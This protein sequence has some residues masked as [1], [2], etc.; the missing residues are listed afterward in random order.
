MHILRQCTEY[1]TDFRHNFK[2]SE[3]K[4]VETYTEQQKAIETKCCY[5][6]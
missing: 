5:V 6:E 1:L 4:M 3:D 2:P